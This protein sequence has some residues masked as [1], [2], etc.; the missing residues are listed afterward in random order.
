MW[1]IKQKAALGLGHHKMFGLKHST[2]IEPEFR[3]PRVI[4]LSSTSLE[5]YL[6]S[7]GQLESLIHTTST[8]YDH[9]LTRSP[10]VF[11]YC[12]VCSIIVR[13]NSLLSIKAR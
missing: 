8:L 11:P 1:S 12:V 10:L 5:L 3:T 13:K 9:D 2:E 6:M 7:R 4:N